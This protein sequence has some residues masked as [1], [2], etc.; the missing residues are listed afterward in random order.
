MA[1]SVRAL[2]Q[3]AATLTSSS[4][5][6]SSLESNLPFGRQFAWSDGDGAGEAD[7]IWSDERTLAAS[8]TEDLDLAGSLTDP[9]GATITLATVKGLIIAADSGN[10]NNVVLGGASSNGWV[11]WVGAATDKVVVRPGGL[12][13]LFA[14]DATAYAVT[15]DTADLLHVANSGSGTSVKYQIIVIG[16]AAA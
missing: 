6:L 4:Q 8:G 15:A 12:L 7:T 9:F 14:P 5:D 1:L 16:V 11:T 13:A 2:V 3:L 10:T